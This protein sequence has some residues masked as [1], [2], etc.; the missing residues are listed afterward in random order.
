MD[1]QPPQ[2]LYADISRYLGEP[3]PSDLKALQAHLI[4]LE[5]TRLQLAKSR[6]EWLRMLHEKENQMLYPK[7]KEKTELDRKTM[8]NASVANIRQDYEFMTRLEELVDSRLS[9]GITLLSL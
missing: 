5:S 2:K 7:D 4:G 6:S 9:F 1:Y 8:L 3:L